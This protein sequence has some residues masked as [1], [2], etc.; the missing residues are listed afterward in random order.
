MTDIY[1]LYYSYKGLLVSILLLILFYKVILRLKYQEIVSRLP[2]EPFDSW[3]IGQIV[4]H[5]G[6]WVVLPTL[7]TTFVWCI[8][9]TFCAIFYLATNIG[10]P[11]QQ[12]VVLLAYIPFPIIT[13]FK[14]FE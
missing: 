10:S 8:I 2:P 5:L 7:Y 13:Y 11:V 14:M 3:F 9:A 1:I 6:L 12:F 4:L